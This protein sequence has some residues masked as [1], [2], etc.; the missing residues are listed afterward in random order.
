M[1]E[2]DVESVQISREPFIYA[3]RVEN[4]LHFRND[5]KWVKLEIYRVGKEPTY[6]RIY[7]W[8]IKDEERIP[9]KLEFGGRS[10]R[11]RHSKRRH[12]TKRRQ[13]L[14]KKHKSRHYK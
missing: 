7:H 11:R 8:P 12:R 9:T 14:R 10:K 6:D 5:K 1:P 13:Q 4:D 3:G 2:T